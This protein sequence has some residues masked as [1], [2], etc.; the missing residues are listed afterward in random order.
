MAAKPTRNALTEKEE[1]TA[2]KAMAVVEQSDQALVNVLGN[3]FYPGA[4]PES[5]RM[6]LEYCRAAGLDP[7]QRP[8]HIVPMWQ[9]SIGAMMDVI[10]P[11]IGL[12]R[13]QAAR[14]GQ[15]AGISDPEFGPVRTEF[16]G[17]QEVTFPEWCKITVKRRMPDGYIAEFSHVER[18]LECYAIKGGKERSVAPNAMWT[19]RAFGQLS[20][21]AEAGALRKAFPEI[22]AVPSAE[23]MQG[24][25]LDASGEEYIDSATGEIVS[26]TRK[27]PARPAIPYCDDET[28][29]KNAA[30]W[31]KGIESHKRTAKELIDVL[32]T[33]YLL[34][35]EQ[36]ATIQEW[37][38]EANR[39]ADNELAA[40]EVNNQ[41]PPQ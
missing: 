23:E 39:E 41:E 21:C 18:W 5:I 27:E 7:M 29:V 1:A 24:K 11:G 8:V 26:P 20:K 14:T 15:Y 36:Q 40:Q 3:S 10:L 12:Y 34:T 16:I 31:R 28:F 38:R 6:V 33:R 19:K 4:K 30:A 9:S 13:T 22:G 37:E 32:Q 25:S 2:Y 17:G 35:E